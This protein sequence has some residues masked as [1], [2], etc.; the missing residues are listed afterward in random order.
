MFNKNQIDLPLL[1][2]GALLTATLIAFVLGIFPYP[3]GLIVL[4]VF[5][6]ARLLSIHNKK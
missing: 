4:T 3:F 5:G 1:I 6:I 2:I